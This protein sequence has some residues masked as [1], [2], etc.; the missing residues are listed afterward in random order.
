MINLREQITIGIILLFQLSYA[1]NVGSVVDND[2]DWVVQTNL[3]RPLFGDVELGVLRKKSTGGDFLVLGRYLWLNPPNSPLGEYSR[4]FGGFNHKAKGFSAGLQYR[5][6]LKPKKNEYVKYLKESSIDR[7]R[8]FYGPYIEYFEFRSS[9]PGY[10]YNYYRPIVS[11]ITIP[12]GTSE[13]KSIG[14]GLLFGS[15]LIEKAKFYSDAYIGLGL[16]QSRYRETEPLFQYSNGK[17]I[18]IGQ[19]DESSFQQVT[20][21]VKFGLNI[22]LKL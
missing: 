21:Q 19:I 10:Y 9:G 20:V 22:G 17:S 14:A 2:P 1:Q 7:K 11:S 3:M 4:H 13:T 5:F 12:D 16:E 8:L 18:Y 6:K 15:T